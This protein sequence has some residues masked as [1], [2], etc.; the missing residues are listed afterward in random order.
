MSGSAR[1]STGRAVHTV[2]DATGEA[3]S[4]AQATRH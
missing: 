3:A 1:H 2:P 4:R